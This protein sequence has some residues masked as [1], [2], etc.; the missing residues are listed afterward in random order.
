M[1]SKW[2]NQKR[3]VLRKQEEEAIAERKRKGILSGREIFAQVCPILPLWTVPKMLTNSI[4]CFA[5]LLRTLLWSL[6]FGLFES[7]A[8]TLTLVCLLIG[9]VRYRWN[10]VMIRTALKVC[11]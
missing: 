3:D 7:Q 2:K 1:F 5:F 9:W 10:V 6:W 11:T 4:A 8:S